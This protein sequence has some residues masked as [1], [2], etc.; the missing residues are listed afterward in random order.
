[1]PPFMK[2]LV[3]AVLLAAGVLL[4]GT[5]FTS[6]VDAH[7]KPGS[8]VSW[9]HTHTNSS[10]GACAYS[11]SQLGHNQSRFKCPKCDCKDSGW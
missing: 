7:G 11:C 1:M 4:A 10:E 2:H 5:T 3:V 9:N 6:F 8:Y